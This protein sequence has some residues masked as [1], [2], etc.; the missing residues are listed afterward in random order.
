MSEMTETLSE[1]VRAKDSLA[2]Q[3]V[4]RDAIILTLMEG[5]PVALKTDEVEANMGGRPVVE[6]TKTLIKLSPPS[7]RKD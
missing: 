5:K 7:E 2:Q 4:A 3:L 6:Q 1:L